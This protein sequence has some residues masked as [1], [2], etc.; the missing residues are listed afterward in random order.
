ML[1]R[2]WPPVF[3][4]A[5]FTELADRLS[6][7]SFSGRRVDHDLDFGDA[8]CRESALFGVPADHVFVQCDVDAVDLV[9]RDVTMQP[10]YLRTEIFQDSARLLGD[11]MEFL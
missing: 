1:V 11:R 5:A 2:A 3:V 6:P 8:G 10:L 9:A 7:A 4:S